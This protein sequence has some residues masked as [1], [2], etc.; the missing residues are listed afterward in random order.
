MTRSSPL[1][2][3]PLRTS[4]PEAIVPAVGV[5]ASAERFDFRDDLFGGPRAVPLRSIF[6][7]RSEAPL[8]AAVSA[9]TPP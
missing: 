1:P 4:A 2:K 7:I 3:S 6:A 8:L 9:S 5:D